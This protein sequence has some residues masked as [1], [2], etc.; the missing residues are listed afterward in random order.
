MLFAVYAGVEV[1]T[2]PG[3]DRQTG[4]LVSIGF[5]PSDAGRERGIL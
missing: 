3:R 5:R 1:G 2:L 4:D